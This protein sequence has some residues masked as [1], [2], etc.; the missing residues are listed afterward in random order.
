MTE[1]PKPFKAPPKRFQ[2]NGTSVL[3][4]DHDILVVD[5]S[6]SLLTVS[7]DKV[8][9]NT[10]YFLLT[11]YVRKGNTRSHERIFIVHRLDR[12]TSGVLIFAKS[13]TAK[14]YLQEHWHEFE[15]HYTA[16]MSGSLKTDEG[17]ITSYL[18]E[19]KAHKMYSVSKAE[20]GKLAK[21]GYK[22]LRKS[23]N[24]TML[25]ISLLTGRK[26]Q[27]RV[28]LAEQGCP[29]AGDRKYSNDKSVKRLMLHSTSLSITHP[30]TKKTM[31]F[32]APLPRIFGSLMKTV[33]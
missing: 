3:Y 20:D 28:H 8:R 25:D 4:E 26:N 11:N 23:K 17:I 27:I 19:N 12:A 2:P 1:T 6:C 31:T 21:T 13:E 30:F 7:N 29:I 18:T 16:I 9:E 10:A 22:T 33:H 15:K 24:Y 32:E 5:K 14:R